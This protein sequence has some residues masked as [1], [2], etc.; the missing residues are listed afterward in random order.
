MH[1]PCST[2]QYS[3]NMRTRQPL[4]SASSNGSCMWILE[5]TDQHDSC[6]QSGRHRRHQMQKRRI[7]VRTVSGLGCLIRLTMLTCSSRSCQEGCL[8]N[9]CLTNSTTWRSGQTQQRP[10]LWLLR[11]RI[12]FDRTRGHSFHGRARCILCT[13]GISAQCASEHICIG[14]PVIL[15]TL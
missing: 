7:A 11:S 3:H 5:C 14:N 12:E 4:L 6:L 9:S 13:S 15:T 2:I 10:S 8:P 1:V